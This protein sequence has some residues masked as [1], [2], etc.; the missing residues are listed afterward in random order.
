MGSL[1]VES[2]VQTYKL[3]CH[4]SIV[5]S[6]SVGAGMSDCVEDGVGGTCT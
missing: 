6:S 3:S 2:S 5:C 4:P 1:V